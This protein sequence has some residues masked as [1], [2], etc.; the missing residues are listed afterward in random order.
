MDSFIHQF[1][2]KWFLLSLS[3]FCASCRGTFTCSII[4][5]SGSAAQNEAVY[6][7]LFYFSNVLIPSCVSLYFFI[8]PRSFTIWLKSCGAWIRLVSMISLKSLGSFLKPLTGPSRILSSHVRSDLGESLRPILL[9]E[10]RKITLMK[11]EWGMNGWKTR[12]EAYIEVARE[13]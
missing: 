12:I 3:L 13:D 5:I 4:T 9:M 1:A 6:Y 7:G 11:L 8:T 2:E 10:M